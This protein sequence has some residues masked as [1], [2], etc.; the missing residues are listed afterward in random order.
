MSR[1]KLRVVLI[2]VV[3]ILVIAAILSGILTYWVGAEGPPALTP[4]DGEAGQAL[5]AVDRALRGYKLLENPSCN[6][7]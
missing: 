7:L 6:S 3:L 4:Q 5:L 2:L 1:T